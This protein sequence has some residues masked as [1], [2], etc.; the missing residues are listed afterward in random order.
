M[1][2]QINRIKKTY[3]VRKQYKYNFIMG[4][5]LPPIRKVFYYYRFFVILY[6]GTLQ[7]KFPDGYCF[8]PGMYQGFPKRMIA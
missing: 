4:I 3:L 6:D 5:I 1:V 2:L 8:V 7:E